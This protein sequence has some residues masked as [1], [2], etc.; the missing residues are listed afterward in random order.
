VKLIDFSSAVTSI[1][2]QWVG[3]GAEHRIVTYVTFKIDDAIKR[4]ARGNY[5]HPNAGRD[6]GLIRR[7]K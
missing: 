1:K 4:L 2:S 7:W 6:C 3:E 5:T